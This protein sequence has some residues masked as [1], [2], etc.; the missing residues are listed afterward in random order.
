[1]TTHTHRTGGVSADAWQGKALSQPQPGALLCRC[2]LSCSNLGQEPV[3][4]RALTHEGT[5]RRALSPHPGHSCRHPPPAPIFSD[6]ESFDSHI[7]SL[8]TPPHSPTTFWFTSHFTS[9]KEKKKQAT[10]PP[11]QTLERI[12]CAEEKET[13]QFLHHSPLNDKERRTRSLPQPLPR[14]PG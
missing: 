10:Q 6:P 11:V 3:S 12:L 7:H 4:G 1:M 14:E 8:P 5:C 2:R 13:H 9:E